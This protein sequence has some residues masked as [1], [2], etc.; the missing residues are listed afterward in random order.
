MEITHFSTTVIQGLGLCSSR[1]LQSHVTRIKHGDDYT[2]SNPTR[3]GSIVHEVAELVHQYDGKGEAS[4]DPN[5]IFDEVWRKHYLVDYDYY[6]LG[7]DQIAG[8]IDRTLYERDGITIATEFPFILDLVELQLWPIPVDVTFKQRSAFVKKICKKV[9]DRGGVPV[10]SMIDRVDRVSETQLE[11]FDYKT[12]MMQ[13]TTDQVDNSIQLALYDMAVRSHWPDT[14]DV[15]CTFDL[16]RHGRQSTIFDEH[17]IETI[18]SHMINLWH[19]VHGWDEPLRTLNQYCGWC[20]YKQNCPVY[21]K[22][23][24]GELIH[25]FV[26]DASI[27][28]AF[29]EHTKLKQVEKLAK[30]RAAEYGAVI[31]AAIMDD[32]DGEPVSLDDGRELYLQA[33]PRYEYPMMDVLPILKKGKAL[34]WLLQAGKLSRPNLDRAAKGHKLADEIKSTLVTTY[35]SPS[36]KARKKS[37]KTRIST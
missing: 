25:P 28:D 1:A 13:F 37:T 9:K 32:N 31:M 35:A 2:G 34:A 23:V 15:K 8:F 33:N 27:A 11:V 36:L 21:A 7:R 5:E 12:N 6:E 18:R 29:T 10:V 17:R 4:P 16:F 3:F 14:E 20:E 30:N 26:D 19:Q 24:G 22:A